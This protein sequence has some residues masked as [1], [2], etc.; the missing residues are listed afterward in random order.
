MKVPYS[1]T[2]LKTEY[3]VPGE[4]VGRII[5]KKGQVV[6]DIQD[7]SHADIEVPKEQQGDDDVPVYVTGTFNGTQ[8]KRSIFRKCY[9]YFGDMVFAYKL[10]TGRLNINKDD[11]FR[12]SHLTTRGHKQKNSEEH[13]TKLPRINTFSNR[14]VKDWNDLSSQIVESSSINSFKNNLDNHW[15]N[16]IYATPF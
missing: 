10:V 11:F 8:V 15:K 1:E 5:G 14:I 16:E 7:K 6:Q 9:C 4:C 13:A 3:M 12:I 2:Q